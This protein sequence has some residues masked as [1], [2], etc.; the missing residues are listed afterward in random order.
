[1]PSLPT[2]KVLNPGAPG[3]VMIV[4]LS[5]L[6]DSMVLADESAETA[7]RR[8]MKKQTTANAAQQAANDAATQA[9]QAAAEA[10]ANAK[11][12][13]D[14]AALAALRAATAE[15]PAGGT[16]ATGAAAS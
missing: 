9:Q 2:A 8:A 7:R 11:I 16:D 4:N 3:G 14:E 15:T 10:E 1:M 6:T 5:D 13:A 12:A